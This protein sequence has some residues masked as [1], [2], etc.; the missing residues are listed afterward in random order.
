MEVEINGKV[1]T[2]LDAL[3]ESQMA[4]WETRDRLDIA[5]IWSGLDYN[6]LIMALHLGFSERA[7]YESMQLK[8]TPTSFSISKDEENKIRQGLHRLSGG[9]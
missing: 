4:L 9:E 2:L 1:K 3:R 8:V 5:Q 7:F 6:D